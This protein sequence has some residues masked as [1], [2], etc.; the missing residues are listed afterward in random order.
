[1]RAPCPAAVLLSC[2]CHLSVEPVLLA[3][4]LRQ[5]AAQMRWPHLLSARPNCTHASATPA[6]S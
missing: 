3:Q 4:S 2:C 6:S 5:A 1:M